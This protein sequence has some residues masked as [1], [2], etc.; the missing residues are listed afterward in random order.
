MS[1]QTVHKACKISALVDRDD[2]VDQIA[3]LEDLNDPKRLDA[4]GAIISL[5]VCSVSCIPAS[6]GSRAGPTPQRSTFPN[7]W[8]GQDSQPNCLWFAGQRQGYRMVGEST[9]GDITIGALERTGVG[10]YRQAFYVRELHSPILRACCTSVIVMFF[11][12][13]A[14]R[15]VNALV[16]SS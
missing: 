12:P 11:A 4:S 5:R 8:E 9:L 1:M 14:T 16:E 10:W 15:P 13:I 2:L 7:R 3:S 6:N